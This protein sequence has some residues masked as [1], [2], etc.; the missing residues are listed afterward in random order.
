MDCHELDP[1]SLRDHFSDEQRVT[2]GAGRRREKLT[3]R[4]VPLFSPTC[5]APRSSFR[6]VNKWE[7]LGN[8][9][10]SKVNRRTVQVWKKS[11]R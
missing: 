3:H 9:I 8:Y 11:A 2:E 4:V 5:H 7:Y 1:Y 6:R 10:V